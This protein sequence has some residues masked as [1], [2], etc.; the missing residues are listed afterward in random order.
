MDFRHL[1]EVVEVADRL[2]FSKAAEALF[3]TQSALSKHVAT[4]EKE[5]GFSIFD[6]SG[7]GVVLTESGKK[8][9]DGAR[10][11]L[12]RSELYLS[13]I[14]KDEEE[15]P[16][17]VVAG[18]LRR[19]GLFPIASQ[20]VAALADRFPNV[21]VDLL[22][23]GVKDYED[24]LMTGK[25]DVVLSCRY[26]DSVR[27]DIAYRHLFDMPF[28]VTVHCSHRLFHEKE[29]RFEDLRDEIVYAYNPLGRSAYSAYLNSV[30]ARY[31]IDEP[32]RFQ[33]SFSCGFP[34]P[35]R[36]VLVCPYFPAY[37]RYFPDYRCIPVSMEQAKLDICS[38]VFKTAAPMNE[39][40]SYLLDAIDEEARVCV[41]AWHAGAVS[42]FEEYNSLEAKL[43]SLS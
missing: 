18:N 6:R 15:S 21:Q 34:D 37:G 19:D 28:G 12:A 39:A 7:G 38:M 33:P 41:E 30:L 8:F 20:A 3:I 16:C 26:P 40:L 29:L 13:R 9:V 27:D 2:N 36:S 14:K 4:V 24:D 1:A 42:E 31:G 22:D 10:D 35:A 25:T 32:T 11:L 23:I 5:V 43:D 17:F